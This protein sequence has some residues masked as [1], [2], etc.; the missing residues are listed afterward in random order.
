MKKFKLTNETKVVL[1]TT[2]YHKHG[3]FR[4]SISKMKFNEIRS[5]DGETIVFWSGFDCADGY[6]NGSGTC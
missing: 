2:L 4:A 1:G 3:L 5:D 6:V